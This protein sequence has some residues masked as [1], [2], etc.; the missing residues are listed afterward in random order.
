M[1]KIRAIDSTNPT[2]PLIVTELV[3]KIQLD[4]FATTTP[5][6]RPRADAAP[7]DKIEE[8][9]ANLLYEIPA[10]KGVQVSKAVANDRSSYVITKEQGRV[11]AWGA[12]E[13]GSV[14]IFWSQFR[15]QCSP[16]LTAVRRQLGL[17]STLTLAC[18]FV[19]TEVA[20]ARSYP[21]GT[22]VKCTDIASGTSSFAAF[23]EWSLTIVCVG[24]DLAYFTVEASQITQK[25]VVDVLACGMG[26]WGALGNGSFT[27]SQG[28]PVKVK[29]ISGNNACTSPSF[30]PVYPPQLSLIAFF[31]QSTKPLEP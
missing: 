6:I 12:N 8:E 21:S 24:G 14:Y 30:S 10:L 28:T 23:D 17:G 31:P 15:K 26:Q 25:P 22:S 5:F 4:P 20:L 29:T 13:Y 19:P 16:R 9:M 18:V 3:P 27:Q 2:G 7:N 1:R 11:L